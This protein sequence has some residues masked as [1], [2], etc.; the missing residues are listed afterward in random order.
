NPDP[1]PHCMCFKGRLGHDC[2]MPQD[3]LCPNK[4]L[5]RGTCHRGFCHCRPPYFGLDCSRQHAWQLA[6]GAVHVP[7][8]ARLRIYM[9][10][11]PSHIA[12][13]VAMDD[14]ITESVFNFYHTY[15]VFLEMLSVDEVVRT[16]NP[17]EA[18]LFY[19][20]AQAYSYSSNTNSPANQIMRAI[21]YVRDTYPWFNASGGRDHFVWTTGDRGS[22]YLPEES[23]G[24]L[25]KRS[26]FCLAPHGA[27][28]GIRLT[29]AM[30]HACVPVIIQDNVWQPYESDGLL[31]YHEFSLRLGKADIPHLVP[32]LR[33]VSEARLAELRLAMARHF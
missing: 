24:D 11:L 5:D 26:K 15:R 20:P 18:N 3:E 25:H 14:D 12:F 32:I 21:S 7:N 6:P 33:S 30:A 13:P 16:E 9:Y 10:D 17:W 31:P 29:I 22:C 27:G 19:V 4:C 8:R 28:F 1:N 2:S 23:Y